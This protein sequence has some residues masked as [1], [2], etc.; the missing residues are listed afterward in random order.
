MTTMGQGCRLSENFTC[1]C[2]NPDSRTCFNLPS[3]HSPA[4]ERAPTMNRR[5]ET[6]EDGRQV[7]R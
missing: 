1:F 3:V 6:N 2:F 5:D 7:K 4:S